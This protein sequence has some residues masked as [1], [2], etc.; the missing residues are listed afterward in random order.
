M[1]AVGALTPSHP[2]VVQ[3]TRA[4]VEVAPQIARRSSREGEPYTVSHPNKDFENS[5]QCHVLTY[6]E[7]QGLHPEHY[8]TT[9]L[10]LQ[11]YS[12]TMW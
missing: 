7:V 5:Q 6:P 3:H 4:A 9:L 11:W 2:I 8:C 1:A 10:V 12:N